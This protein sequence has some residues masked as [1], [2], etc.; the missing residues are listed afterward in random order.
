[1]SVRRSAERRR[2]GPGSA[3][4]A[5][6]QE[7]PHGE[8]LPGRKPLPCTMYPRAVCAP[9][10][11]P[12]PDLCVGPRAAGGIRAG[13]SV[14]VRTLRAVSAPGPPAP[15]RDP[16]AVSA[17]ELLRLSAHPEQCPRRSVH[18]GI[19]RLFS[20]CRV[21]IPARRRLCSSAACAVERPPAAACLS[22]SSSVK[23]C[24]AF[25]F[26]GMFPELGRPAAVAQAFVSPR[27]TPAGA[28]IFP[29]ADAGEKRSHPGSDF[30]L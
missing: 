8:L 12:R 5:S 23:P 26:W 3:A 27:S 16:R 21:H 4:C 25:S 18:S 30:D 11:C 22:G 19:P 14:S 28:K 1:M 2:K 24:A 20:V 10:R 9:G 17:P 6:R 13:G 15:V 7:A 29:T